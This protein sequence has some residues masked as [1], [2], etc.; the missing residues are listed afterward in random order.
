[1][2]PTKAMGAIKQ[3]RCSRPTATPC[4]TFWCS[5]VVG[6]LRA[7]ER[8]LCLIGYIFRTKFSWRGD[9]I[10][11][12][13]CNGRAELVCLSRSKNSTITQSTVRCLVGRRISHVTERRLCLWRRKL[14]GIFDAWWGGRNDQLV[15]WRPIPM[16]QPACTPQTR[17]NQG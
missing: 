3:N 1:M 7:I 6:F 14:E 11:W 12:P 15:T 10:P 2:P 4:L 16:G 17:H 13:N 9:L 8:W 5:G